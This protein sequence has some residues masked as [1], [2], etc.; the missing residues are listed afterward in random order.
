MHHKKK[1]KN[2]K[3]PEEED[4]NLGAVWQLTRDR[5]GC[6]SWREIPVKKAPSCRHMAGWEY[7]DKMWIFGGIGPSPLDIGHLNHCVDFSIGSYDEGTNNQLLC[8]DPS[9]SEWT[10]LK[11]LEQYLHLDAIVPPHQLVMKPGCMEEAEMK[12]RQ[13]FVI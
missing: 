8:F 1:N 10:N 5:E 3:S 6:F 12:K 2:K 13:S 4:E 11:V 7:S 9:C